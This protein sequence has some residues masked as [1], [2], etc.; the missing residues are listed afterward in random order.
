MEANVKVDSAGCREAQ[1]DPHHGEVPTF[2]FPRRAV[3]FAALMGT[4][5]LASSGVA[6]LAMIGWR[7]VS[8]GGER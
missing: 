8:Q 4:P 7:S 1:A 3:Q 6:R 2:P 5:R